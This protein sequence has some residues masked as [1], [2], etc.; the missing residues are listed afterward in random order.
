MVIL[1]EKELFVCIRSLEQN[2][3]V[4]IGFLIDDNMSKI[5]RSLLKVDP[6]PLPDLLFKVSTYSI[7]NCL[8]QIFIILHH[9]PSTVI[10]FAIVCHT[11]HM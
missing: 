3:E 10:G 11:C 9:L 7:E 8:T 1:N 6:A 2:Y 5:Q 4:D